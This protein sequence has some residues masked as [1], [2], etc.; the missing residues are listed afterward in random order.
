MQ[1]WNLKILSN[2]V[3]VCHVQGK[4]LVNEK[5]FQVMEKSGITIFSPGN[6]EKME[7]SGSF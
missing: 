2:D 5:K 4:I 1:V 7:K 6:L 3:Q